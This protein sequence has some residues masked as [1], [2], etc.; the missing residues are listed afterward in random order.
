MIHSAIARDDSSEWREGLRTAIR[1]QDELLN[2]LGLTDSEN[3]LA[4]QRQFAIRVPRDFLRRMQPGNV[5][6]PLLRQVLASAEE[7]VNVPGYSVD[8]LAESVSNPIPGLIHK[9][10]DRALIMP[11]AACAVHCRYCFRR[12]FPYEHNRLDGDALRQVLDYLEA[13]QGLNEV[14]LS[15]GDP[16]ILDDE[17]LAS[18]IGRLATVVHLKR[19]RIHSRV[20][21]VIPQRLT[22]GL[23][24]ALL[25]SRL[26][27]TL[28]VHC[29]HPQE[30]DL[31]TQEY[32]NH[33]TQRGIPVLN[34]TVLLQG[35]NDDIDTLVS[36]SER[37]WD[38]GIHPYYLHM[39][40]PVQGSHQFAITEADAMTLYRQLQSR[41]SGYL[42]PNLVREVTGQANKVR[43]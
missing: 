42:V 35:I 21:I 11:T 38:C 31:P 13:N 24:S 9:Y 16:L 36:L 39:L 37:L 15:G 26:K 17:Y 30:L 5:N 28:V 8:P 43:F 41:L 23:A 32:F 34:Q 3:S 1:S 29:N 27:P 7:M 25:S 19:V 4:G 22:A 6:D 18:L 20:P 10:A 33:W 14:I 12:H 40:D 2:A